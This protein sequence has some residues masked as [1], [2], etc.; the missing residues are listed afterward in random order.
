MA[1]CL[2]EHARCHGDESAGLPGLRVGGIRGRGHRAQVLVELARRDAPAA[3]LLLPAQARALRRG[4]SR[5]V[6]GVRVAMLHRVLR[7]TL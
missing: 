5:V 4:A 1:P 2:L 6:V 7:L 3:Q